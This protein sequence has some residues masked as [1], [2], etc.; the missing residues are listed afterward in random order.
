MNYSIKHNINHIYNLKRLEFARIINTMETIKFINALENKLPDNIRSSLY[1]QYILTNHNSEDGRMVLYSS[2]NTRFNTNAVCKDD[3]HHIWSE[4]N[5]LVLDTKNIKPLVVPPESFRTNVEV[6]TVNKHLANDLYNLYLVEDGTVINLYY[7]PPLNSWRISTT[8]CYDVTD[9]KWCD[10]TYNEILC[11][12]LSSVY[13]TTDVDFYNMLDKDTSYT[14]GFKHDSMHP[15]NENKTDNINKIW[16]IQSF[17]KD[18]VSYEFE[19]KF[20]IPTQ[21]EFEFPA[22]VV[23]N[24]KFLFNKLDHSYDYYVSTGNVLYGYIL[25]SKNPS[26]TGS[27]SNILLESSLLKRIRKLYYHSGFNDHAKEKNYNR[28]IYT[29]IHSYL[30]INNRST[31]IKLFPQYKNQYDIL[32]MI[33]TLLI[34]NINNMI[35]RP[36]NTQ[37]LISEYIIN[38]DSTVSN[39]NL[40]TDVLR[41][42]V[43]FIYK[44]MT[45]VYQLTP[46]DRRN[47][48]VIST[49]ILNN[50]F[51]DLYYAL[52]SF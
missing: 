14:F 47:S 15:F 36:H 27:H 12:L 7:W 20:N 16:F 30:N 29:I 44:S 51:N 3:N 32:G 6:D 39:F 28:E 1:K 9:S 41:S 45:N 4:C 46:R 50:N 43:L 38:K 25:R 21:K 24:T 52:F 35:N 17:H 5:G 31:F 18:K 33:T 2:K 26:E 11:D 40:N 8:R 48:M 23:K 37:E 10:L 49:Y 19:N 42:S 34:K 22:G 13:N